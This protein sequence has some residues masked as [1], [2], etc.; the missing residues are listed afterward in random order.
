MTEIYSC[1]A[2]SHG[3]G[4]EHPWDMIIGFDEFTPGDAFKPLNHKKCMVLS[5]NFEQLGKRLLNRDVTWMT[6]LVMRHHEIASIQGGWSRVFRDY[7]RLH[8]LGACGAVTS[9]VPIHLNGAVAL[10]YV[11]FTHLLAD[12]DGW[13]IVFDWRGASSLKPCR[14]KYM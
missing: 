14:Y 4:P 7:L 12:G 10:I 9:G 5:F 6:P 8:L 11:K 3:T 1:I 13:R 2:N